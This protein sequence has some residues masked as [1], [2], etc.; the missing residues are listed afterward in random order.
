M[1]RP[2]KKQIIASVMLLTLFSLISCKLEEE[3]SWGDLLDQASNTAALTINYKT[4]EESWNTFPGFNEESL[5]SHLAVFSIPI[6]SKE[7]YQ[8]SIHHNGSLEIFTEI[9]PVEQPGFKSEYDAASPEETP[10]ETRYIHFNEGSVLYYDESMHLIHSMNQDLG[11]FSDV[12]EEIKKSESK[13]NAVASGMASGNPFLWALNP[14]DEN[15]EGVVKSSG[16]YTRLKND[17][18]DEAT[19]AYFKQELIVNDKDQTIEQIR[20]YNEKNEL[21]DI[22]WLKYDK[23]GNAPRLMHISDASKGEIDG[24]E[25][26]T[27]TNTQYENFQ[28]ALN[29][30]N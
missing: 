18:F 15:V 11:D 20:N 4:S 12:L 16:G 17:Y 21:I 26:V 9:I 10:A 27:Q 14:A 29:L 6:L 2:L 22:S 3:E 23:T 1:N 19:Q 5:P 13:L 30:K 24:I 25:T 8:I 7:N 28:V